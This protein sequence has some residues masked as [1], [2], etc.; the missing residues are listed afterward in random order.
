MNP[1][2][3]ADP[4]LSCE[5]AAQFENGFFNGEQ[6]EW[7]IMQAAGRQLAEHIVQDSKELGVPLSALNGLVLVGKGH[8][9]GD[10]LLACSE[11]SKLAPEVEW[12]ICL[13]H[14][15][16]QLRPLTLRA[17]NRLQAL[18]P[19]AELYMLSQSGEFLSRLSTFASDLKKCFCIDGLLGFNFQPP[20]NRVL[21]NTIN[22]VNASAHIILRAAIDL[23]TGLS[24][25]FEAK[26][27]V[28]KADFI[29]ATG[30]VKKPLF[31]GSARWGRVRYLDLGFFHHPQNQLSYERAVL[32]SRALESVQGLR[33]AQCDKRSFGHLLIVAGSV[34]MPGALILCLQAAIRSG[35]GRITVCAPQSL[36]PHIALHAPEAMWLPAP[37]TVHGQLSARSLDKIQDSI[38]RF[39]ACLCGPGIGTGADSLELVKGL[40]RQLGIPLLLDA[41]AIQPEIIPKLKLRAGL[42]GA[43]AVIL[44]PHVGE[45]RRL[46]QS[47]IQSTD[48]VKLQQFCQKTHCMTVLKGAQSCFSNGQ[49][50]IYSPY[51][52]PVLARGGVEICSRA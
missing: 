41:D 19:S 29:Y 40:I 7:S 30:I 18:L 27:P 47:D 37:E 10:A 44:T 26:S 6:H 38:G 36:L 24:S 45:Y 23:P 25:N 52:G 48:A 12:L 33:P 35:V 4:I 9:G 50:T 34:Q 49:Y 5:Q 1:L 31:D 51:G 16:N 8:N 21:A 2:V 43:A 17:L 32:N 46:L 14:A 13:S 11:L 39:T 3:Y 15:P 20:L 42:E 22:A 28:F